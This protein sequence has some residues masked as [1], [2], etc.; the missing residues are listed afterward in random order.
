MPEKNIV[1][2]E[3]DVDGFY[4]TLCYLPD[5]VV[6]DIATREMDMGDHKTCLCGWALRAIVAKVQQ[7]TTERAEPPY[8]SIVGGLAKRVG[9]T[10]SEW[11]DIFI[12]V[13]DDEK[14]LKI[15]LAW[16]YR[17][18]DA[19]ERAGYEALAEV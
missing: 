4:T 8:G 9:G 1:E 12:G 19:V 10:Q 6:L 15:E 18:D 13:C 11:N 17:V 7:V 2:I 14:L 5:D 3:E 16:V